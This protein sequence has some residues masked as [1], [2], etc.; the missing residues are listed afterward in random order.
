MSKIAVL[1]Y[2]VVGSGTVEVFYAAKEKIQKKLGKDFDIKYILDLRDFPDSPYADKFTKNYDDIL[3]D[4]EVSIVV[5]AMG[6][7]HPAFEFISSA[8]KAGKSAVTSN[9]ELVAKKGAELLKLADENNVS[10]L[11]EASVG[12]GVPLIRPIYRCLA[13]N[14][15]QEIAGILNGTTNFILTKM[16]GENMDFDVAL[17]MAQDL[18]YAERDPSA[19]VDGLDSCR[20]ICIL[21]SLAYGKHVYPDSVKTE[22]IRNITIEDVKYA[23]SWGGKIKLIGWSKRSG[24]KVIA[25]VCPAFIK[26]G[27]QLASAS[28][29][30]NAI[31]V[32]GSATGDVV[33]Y[34]KGAGKLPTASA[35]IGDV[36][37][38]INSPSTPKNLTWEDSEQDFI[39]CPC[40]AQLAKYVRLTSGNPDIKNEI[41]KVFGS[42]T[43]L[44][45]DNKPENEHAFVT[46]VLT[47]GEIDKKL[48]AL[49]ADIISTVRVLDY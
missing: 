36:I 10:F 33:F 19:D 41:E 21:S 32:R 39:E 38:I 4:G 43:Y 2:G 30:F 6:G 49:D 40:K 34:G 5:E 31:L 3:N 20:K 1:G 37:D 28:D 27:S 17:K 24:D 42:V 22:G 47:D 45:R 11:F 14:E 26:N 44:D 9:K 16:F 8:L 46:P 48:S 25:M 15:I 12:G 29:V 13:A 35:M 7:L 23:D 18:G